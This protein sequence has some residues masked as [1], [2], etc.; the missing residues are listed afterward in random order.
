MNNMEIQEVVSSASSMIDA[1]CRNLDVCLKEASIIDLLAYLEL[2][3]KREKID[4]FKT[5]IEWQLINAELRRR[6]VI[7]TIRLEVNTHG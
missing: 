3:T 2:M 1:I 6:L 4:P 5:Y 7:D